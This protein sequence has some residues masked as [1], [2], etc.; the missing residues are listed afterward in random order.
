MEHQSVYWFICF[1][2]LSSYLFCYFQIIF[3]SYLCMGSKIIFWECWKIA[4]S[5]KLLFD[6]FIPSY[7]ILILKYDLNDSHLFL[8]WKPMIVS[9][10]NCFHIFALQ[11]KSTTSWYKNSQ[12]V[13]RSSRTTSKTSRRAAS[14]WPRW[15]LIRFP[16]RWHDY[17]RRYGRNGWFKVQK[18][19][20][21]RLWSH[22]QNWLT[23]VSKNTFHASLIISP[24]YFQHLN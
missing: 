19:P 4:I 22:T 11:E 14:V 2:T 12:S 18:P 24:H 16:W 8:E 17:P 23:V 15:L 10:E 20:V 3:I 13:F 6:I 5:Q 1:K 9:C 7:N 21:D